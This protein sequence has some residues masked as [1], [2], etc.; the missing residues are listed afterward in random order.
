MLKSYVSLVERV[1]ALPP[2]SKPGCCPEMAYP[3]NAV[4]TDTAGLRRELKELLA[5]AGVDLAAQWKEDPDAIPS[6][7]KRYQEMLYR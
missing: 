5:R 1:N 4:S 3:D 6:M 7:V 2:L